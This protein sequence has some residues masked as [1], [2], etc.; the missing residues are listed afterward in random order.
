MRVCHDFQMVAFRAKSEADDRLKGGAETFAISQLRGRKC[1][2][3][4]ETN[5]LAGQFRDR[6]D[7]G[8]GIILID[9]DDVPD[10]DKGFWPKTGDWHVAWSAVFIH[11]R[12]PTPE[13]VETLIV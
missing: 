4:T 3:F 10:G 1:T 2:V 7:K 9:L 12:E 5:T 6:I 8:G 13:E 11:G